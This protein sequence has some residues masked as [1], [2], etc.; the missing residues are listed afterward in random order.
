ML[1]SYLLI[2]PASEMT[3]WQNL[4]VAVLPV[5]GLVAVAYLQ[6]VY[7]AGKKRG[8]DALEANEM[9][10]NQWKMNKED[11]D[12]VVEQINT[13]GKNLGRSIDRVESTVKLNADV[14]IKIDEK[15]DTH[16]RDHAV[17]KF[18]NKKN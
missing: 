6:F 17:G 15:L 5:L 7:K 13:L 14:V 9:F 12:F 18:V 4:F 16:I 1:F 11:H 8:K 3:S 2:T 10:M